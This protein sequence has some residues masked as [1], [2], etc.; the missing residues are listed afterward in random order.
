MFHDRE[1][2]LPIL[3][4]INLKEFDEKVKEIDEMYD[5]YTKFK[6]NAG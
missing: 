6:V 2:T 5:L 4:E 3:E 1:Y